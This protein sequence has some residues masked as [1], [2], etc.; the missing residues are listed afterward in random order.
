MKHIEEL[1]KVADRK[2]ERIKSDITIN[3]KSKEVFLKY[4]EYKLAENISTSRYFRIVFAFS[5][6]LKNFKNVDFSALTQ[7]QAD[8][9]WI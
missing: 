6:V 9:I 5:H 2:L 1:K 8:K 7:E 4:L 3:Q